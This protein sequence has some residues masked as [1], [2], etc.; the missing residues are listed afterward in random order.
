MIPAARSSEQA[1]LSLLG[2]RCGDAFGEKFFGNSDQCLP[3]LNQR[4]LPDAPWS[5]TDDTLMAVSIVE[6][7]ERCGEIDQDALAQSF[8]RKYDPMRGYGPAMHG[9]L[10]EIR[11]G[12]SWRQAAPALFD[13][14]GS[15]GNG[16]A[17]RVAPL[18]AYYA[19]GDLDVLVVEAM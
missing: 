5:Y 19:D 15:Y 11:H 10:A 14:Q 1:K 17:M 7:L 3:L 12:R 9:L 4:L 6:T 16:A 18:G 8:A 2:L 13:G